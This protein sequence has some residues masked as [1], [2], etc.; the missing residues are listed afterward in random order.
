VST[1]VRPHQ[2][3]L[4]G[5]APVGLNATGDSDIRFFYDQIRAEQEGLKA[6]I[7]QLIK[8]INNDAQ[9]QVSIEFP[10]LWQMTDGEKAELRRMEAG[11]NHIYLQEGV[12]LPEEVAL[13]RFSGGEFSVDLTSRSELLK[14]EKSTD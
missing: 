14:S 3:L 10:A 12:L 6:K 2:S 5:Q 11:T 1:W 4:V 7:E 13:K 8:I 9:G